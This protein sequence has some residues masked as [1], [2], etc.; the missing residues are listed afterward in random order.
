MCLRLKSNE[1]LTQRGALASLPMLHELVHLHAENSSWCTDT[2][3]EHVLT[4]CAQ[5]HELTIVGCRRVTGAS[6]RLIR[7]TRLRALSLQHVG[8]MTH[9]Q[10]REMMSCR[11]LEGARLFIEGDWDLRALIED[12]KDNMDEESG[13]ARAN[14]LA[15]RSRL[16]KLSLNL[17]KDTTDETLFSVLS[18]L[19]SS[20]GGHLTDL[21]LVFFR[22]SLSTLAL[23]GVEL[24]CFGT[25]RRLRLER[26]DDGP[27]GDVAL[28]RVLAACTG[29]ESLHLC[30]SSFTDSVLVTV[31]ERCGPRLRELTVEDVLVTDSGLMRIVRDC[32]RLKELVVRYCNEVTD[33]P[34]KELMEYGRGLR[35]LSFECE[36]IGDEAWRS[37]CEGC[38]YLEILELWTIVGVPREV[39]FSRSFVSCIT[40]SANNCSRFLNP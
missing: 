11:T 15:T 1:L 22:P 18:Y 12:P 23:N 28:S 5:L 25:L 38:P 37:M 40:E 26:W 21:S 30:E 14:H 27:D 35:R 16:C 7:R 6:L 2:V 32:H 10:I 17:S 36:T 13:P 20:N 4:G 8:E 39:C 9:E 34:L 29:L 3:V 31:A 19:G 24:Y 33:T